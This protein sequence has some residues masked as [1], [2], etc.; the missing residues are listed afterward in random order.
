MPG[1]RLGPVQGALAVSTASGRSTPGDY[2]GADL[3]RQRRDRGVA[4]TL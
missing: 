2:L 3:L 1:A 4:G